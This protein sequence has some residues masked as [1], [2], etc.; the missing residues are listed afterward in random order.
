LLCQA[1]RL[2]TAAREQGR[3]AE[4]DSGRRLEEAKVRGAG[5]VERLVQKGEALLQASGRRV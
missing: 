3:F 2:L 5:G 1:L 4:L